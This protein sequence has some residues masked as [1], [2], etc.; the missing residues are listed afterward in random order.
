MLRTFRRLR[1]RM[2]FSY[3]LVTIPAIVLIQAC[4]LVFIGIVV[5]A[6]VNSQVLAEDQASAMAIVAPQ[7]VP[8]IRDADQAS[9][10]RW[11]HS[12]TCATPGTPTMFPKNTFPAVSLTTIVDAS[13]RVLADATASIT[14]GIML[15]QQLDSQAATVLQAALEGQT[16]PQALAIRRPD[17]TLVAA[18]P[19][20]DTEQRTLGAWLVMV[21]ETVFFNRD[22][23]IV[24]LLVF[25][26]PISIAATGIAIVLGTI[27]GSL[28]SRNLV[29]RLRAL[30]SAANAWSAGDFQVVAQDASGDE[31][32]ALSRR[33][34]Q[35]AEQLRSLVA[36]RQELATIEERNRLARDLHDSVKQ[37]LFAISMQLASARTLLGGQ[38]PVDALLAHA[39]TLTQG[40]QHEVTATIHALRPAA[41]DEVGLAE[42]LRTHVAEWSQQHQVVAE[43]RYNGKRDL[44]LAVEQVLFRVA[45]E[46][47]ANVARH[48][49]ATRVT[50]D[51]SREHQAVTQTIADNGCG[52]QPD[53]PAPGGM[54]L[55][56]MRERV[57]AL[58]G[59]LEL[60]SR[61]GAG[62]RI[63]AQIPLEPTTDDRRLT[64]DKRPETAD[65]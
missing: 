14:P 21:D 9:L 1:W 16:A 22:E 2:T 36:T 37:Q 8:Y 23:A 49:H 33:L 25:L 58:G 45:Q 64:T 30:T 27:Y 24:V 31:L 42:A 57:M 15:A 32:G 29:Q 43:V 61:P 50:I 47:L 5:Y 52:F 55:R 12:T 54:G 46:A 34:N 13:G 63:I 4:F 35:M 7:A 18:A 44:P 40:A 59:T 11:L 65:H 60:E 51:I 6:F 62:T 17:N 41:L 28:T 56:S 20:K 38:A 26:I 39:E 53:T 10:S 3:L 48:S 19:I